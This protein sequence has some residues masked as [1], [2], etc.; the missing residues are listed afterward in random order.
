MHTKLSFG[1]TQHGVQWDTDKASRFKEENMFVK[2]IE[3]SAR[4]EYI[5]VVGRTWYPHTSKG[6]STEVAAM[7]FSLLINII[8][9]PPQDN[10]L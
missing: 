7:L 10:I 9:H 3:V 4:G 6:S 1:V 5:K 8:Q 2:S